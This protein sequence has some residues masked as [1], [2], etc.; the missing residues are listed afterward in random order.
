M[1]RSSVLFFVDQLPNTCFL[2]LYLV[3]ETGRVAFVHRSLAMRRGASTA[4]RAVV[5]A[6]LVCVS[7]CAADHVQQALSNK[8]D[9]ASALVQLANLSYVDRPTSLKMVEASGTEMYSIGNVRACRALA[10]AAVHCVLVAAI[11]WQGLCVPSACADPTTLRTMLIAALK[12]PNTTAV[13]CGDH[14][15]G[16]PS[17][18]F[19]FAIVVLVALVLAATIATTVDMGA[20]DGEAARGELS[21]P[22]APLVDEDGEGRA[23]EGEEKEEEKETPPRSLLV[24][25]FSMARAYDAL[26]DFN[27]RRKHVLDGLR[28][29]SLSWIIL[30]HTLN[31]M[32]DIGMN[33]P[34]DFF[35]LNGNNGAFACSPF[36]S[37]FVVSASLAVDTFFFLSAFLLTL[38]TLRRLERG[39]D[40]P[41]LLA[42]VNR[43]ARL[44]PTLAFLIL[45]FTLL[46]PYA[47]SG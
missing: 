10:P 46:V 24:S 1:T 26:F 23:G 36:F 5:L 11:D 34:L 9:C 22:L 28:A 21:E 18:G 17:S 25:S 37:V 42:I 33:N 8:L 27:D 19:W 41:V 39:K 7:S 6:V 20:F 15:V 45:V 2:Q 4:T 13:R 43:Y 12:L 14:G 31:F 44:V 16:T 32:L 35:P 40:V 29:L 3:L 38:V 47:G 30:G